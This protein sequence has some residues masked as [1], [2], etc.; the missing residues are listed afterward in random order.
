M[1]SSD[2]TSSRAQLDP[3]QPER[4]AR[5]VAGEL[6]D[7][8]TRQKL[9]CLRGVNMQNPKGFFFCWDGPATQCNR[10]LL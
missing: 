3:G 2:R 1:T 7:E 10:G 6:P 9:N 4:A 8:S 5:F